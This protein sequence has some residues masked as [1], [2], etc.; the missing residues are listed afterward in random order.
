[1]LLFWYRKTKTR[2]SVRSPKRVAHALAEFIKRPQA[3][4]QIGATGTIV[5]IETGNE[6]ANRK[7]VAG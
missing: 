1:V 6:A 5:P 3:E 7:V 2:F 4:T